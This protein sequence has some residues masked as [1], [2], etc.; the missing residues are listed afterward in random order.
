MRQ[1]A[2][3]LFASGE[4]AHE[5]LACADRI[6]ADLIVM[7]T[8]GR[9]QIGRFLLGSVTQEVLEHTVRPV[10]VTGPADQGGHHASSH[11]TAAREADISGV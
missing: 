7:G 2:Y 8:H 6:S 9:S 11:N 5:I 1:I 3:P 4:P 10:L